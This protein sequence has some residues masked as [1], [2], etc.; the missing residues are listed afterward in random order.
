MWIL[1]NMYFDKYWIV[2]D[3]DGLGVDKKPRIG[4][5]EKL[6]GGVLPP[7]KE[8]PKT[9]PTDPT[10]PKTDPTDPG[11]DPVDPNPTDPKTDPTDP[12]KNPNDGKEKPGEQTDNTKTEDPLPESTSGG[13]G[14]SAFVV[15][16]IILLFAIGIALFVKF[17]GK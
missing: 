10:D 16:F 5:W 13:G 1:G 7:K 9:D 15:I 11:K 6:P 14:G 4:I 12:S 8:D 2:N 17:Y 3:A